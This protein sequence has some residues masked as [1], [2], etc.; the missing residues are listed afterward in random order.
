MEEV[1]A[2]NAGQTS[3][4][5]W[6]S[7]AA[8][9]THS[10]ERIVKLFASASQDKGAYHVFNPVKTLREELGDL[11]LYGHCDKANDLIFTHARHGVLLVAD[12]DGRQ[13]LHV[14]C[15]LGLTGIACTMLDLGSPL[16]D[17]DKDGNQPLH[18]ACKNSLSS[19]A[20][21]MLHAKQEVPIHDRNKYG[22]Q[23][24][25][26]ACAKGLEE[27]VMLM[28]EMG[29]KLDAKDQAERQAVHLACKF[30][31]DRLVITII[32]A[33]VRGCNTVPY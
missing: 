30:G 16:V 12:D 24:L 5:S 20:L 23:P 29:A 6:G 8:T 11:M 2:T 10:S 13:P 4:D 1:S 9:T 3:I 14:A 28:V 7:D 33:K 21:A 15:Q 17:A 32:N 31:H 19:V 26:I 22:D 25:H 27:V 18:I